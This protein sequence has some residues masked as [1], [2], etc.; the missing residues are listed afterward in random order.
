[1]A[2]RVLIVDDQAPFRQ[3]AR[4]VV[5][6]TGGFEVA[7]EAESG[8]EAVFLARRLNPDLVLMDVNLPDFSGTVATGRILTEN[9]GTTVLL[10][11][12]YEEADYSPH[13]IE[14]GAA[15]YLSK[16]G[17]TPDRLRQAWAGTGR[18]PG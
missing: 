7:G 5:E 6:A 2:V 9:D 16:A 1:M 3:V 14:C 15:G 4:V 18:A 10:V 12:T 17:L 8:Q 13:A 11:S